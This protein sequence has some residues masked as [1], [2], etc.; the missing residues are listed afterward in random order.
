MECGAARVEQG[1]HRSQPRGKLFAER[2]RG[3]HGIQC[4][5]VLLHAYGGS[6]AQQPSAAIVH[7][8]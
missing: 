8:R 5:V 1:G 7:T 4:V 6:V 2:D 3:I